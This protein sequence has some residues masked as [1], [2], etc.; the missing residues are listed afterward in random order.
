MYL[1]RA[2]RRSARVSLFRLHGEEEAS[3]VGQKESVF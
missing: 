1:L 2:E 3:G